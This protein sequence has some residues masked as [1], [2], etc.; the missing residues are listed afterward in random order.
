MGV[1]TGVASN[2]LV[3][4]VDLPSGPAS[5]AE[6]EGRFERLPV[7]ATSRTG[8]GGRQV[9]FSYPAGVRVRNS[10]GRLGRGL[11][12]RA[13][14][15]FVLLPPSVH[16]SGDSYAWEVPP[17]EVPPA[18]PPDWLIRLLVGGEGPG[19]GDAQRSSA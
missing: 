15:G 16:P 17:W 7:T 8:G 12:I 14:G 11:D 4:D 3:A 13:E 10:A 5:L 2:L 6:L 1:A 18:E 19:G 9:F